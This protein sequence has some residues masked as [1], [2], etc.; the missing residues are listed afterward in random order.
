MKYK[1][2]IFIYVA[3]NII[4]GCTSNT[5]FGLI[6]R[7]NDTIALGLGYQQSLTRDNILV[8]VTDA[9]LNETIVPDGDIRALIN[10]YPDPLSKMIVNQ[11]T[12]LGGS[13][14]AT[15]IE[16]VI[17]FDDK[18]YSE[19]VLIMDLPEVMGTGIATIDITDIAGNPIINP[20]DGAGNS[21]DSM[22]VEIV[23]TNGASDDFSV[24]EP[25][26]LAQQYLRAQERAPHYTVT[27]QGTSVPHA[28]E[29][30]LMHDPDTDNG[31]TGKAYV[32]NPRGDIKNI[33]WSDDGISTLKVILIP[34]QSQTLENIKHFKFYV[35]GGLTG[36]IANTG[37]VKA[38]DINGSVIS[39]ITAAVE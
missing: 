38:Y 36:L 15:L 30:D 25:I 31:G 19:T 11:E 8:K 7:A 23:S 28:I 10:S 16:G 27:F 32:V 18:D 34:T 21:I 37:S 29:V 17:S 22:S 39:G 2:L 24:Q 33:H 20:Y 6:A 35:A 1:H 14:A 9:D 13:V 12:G 4:T 5:N 26:L 3:V